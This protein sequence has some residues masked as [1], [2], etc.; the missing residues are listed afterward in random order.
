M[1]LTDDAV[2]SLLEM[3]APYSDSFSSAIERLSTMKTG[4]PIS[5]SFLSF[6]NHRPLHSL[7]KNRDCTVWHSKQGD[8]MAR[9]G[10]G[11]EA[12]FTY[13]AK[14]GDL[15]KIGCSRSDPYARIRTISNNTGLRLSLRFYLHSQCYRGLEK[16]LHES[17]QHLRVSGEFFRL[18]QSELSA[19][20]RISYFK[21]VP[22]KHYTPIYFYDGS[23]NATAKRREFEYFADP[24]FYRHKALR[25]ESA[26]SSDEEDRL[27]KMRLRQLIDHWLDVHL[28]P[29]SEVERHSRTD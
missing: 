12:G 24:E 11:C 17:Y 21:G 10:V 15:Y 19:I 20:R 16:D 13:I 27:T 7:L 5:P 14:V 6:F 22:V 1:K 9:S 4:Y 8:L 29:G 18:S 26:L 3:L 23:D 2:K 25:L 28:N